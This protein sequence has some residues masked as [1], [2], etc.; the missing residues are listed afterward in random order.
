M[1]LSEFKKPVPIIESKVPPDDGP[2]FGLIE[3]THIGAKATAESWLTKISVKILF[4]VLISIFHGR[5]SFVKFLCPM[6]PLPQEYM[7][8]KQSIAKVV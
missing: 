2:Q 7:F 3:Y 1:S 5:S 8:P 4:S 6:C